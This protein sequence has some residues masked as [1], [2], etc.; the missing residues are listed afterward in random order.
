MFPLHL[1]KLRQVLCYLLLH[2]H[3]GFLKKKRNIFKQSLKLLSSLLCNQQIPVT[4]EA[5]VVQEV[6][7]Q[8]NQDFIDMF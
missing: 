3:R 4:T 7:C 5:A 2:A 1:S 8:K 6:K